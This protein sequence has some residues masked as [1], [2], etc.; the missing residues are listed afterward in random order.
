MFGLITFLI[1]F[2][3]ICGYLLS[4]NIQEIIQN[5]KNKNKYQNSDNKSKINN[6]DCRAAG[7]ILV[8]TLSKIYI[9][10]F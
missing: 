10:L 5:H 3:H 4:V 1:I 6:N 2:G 9:K 7:Y 8:H